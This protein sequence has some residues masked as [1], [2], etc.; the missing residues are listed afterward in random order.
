MCPVLG[1]FLAFTSQNTALRIRKGQ[2][3]LRYWMRGN[4][5]L[6]SVIHKLFIFFWASMGYCDVLAF[7]LQRHSTMLSQHSAVREREH[8]HGVRPPRPSV[9]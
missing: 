9:S 2:G 8:E 5:T 7:T 3:Q 4:R 1:N 6:L